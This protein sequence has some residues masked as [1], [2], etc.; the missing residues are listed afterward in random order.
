MTVL[1]HICCAHCLLAVLQPLTEEG[2]SLRGLFYNPNIQPFIEFRRRLKALKLLAESLNLDIDYDEVYRLEAFL[3]RV[4]GRGP[5]RCGICYR[6][7]LTRTARHAREVGC[8]SFTTTLLASV[9]QQHDLVR[10]VGERAGEEEGVAFLYGDW[11][12]GAA[13]AHEEA[14]RRH[15]YL[16]PYCGCIYS[17]YERFKDTTTHVYRGPG[18]G[19]TGTAH[20]GTR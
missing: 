18:G 6:D 3:G 15:L 10:R 9:H 19:R 12:E 17:E 5:G 1:V 2:H 13:A 7:R 8:D 11:R 4:V 16:Q 20:G 14:R